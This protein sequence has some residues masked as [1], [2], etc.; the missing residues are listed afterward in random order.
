EGVGEI[1]VVP[2]ADTVRQV[3]EERDHL[4][5]A[6]RALLARMGVPDLAA[7]EARHQQWQ[8]LTQQLGQ[9]ERELQIHLA[10]QSLLDCTARRD[11]LAGRHRGLVEQ[12]AGLQ[13]DASPPTSLQE[14][15]Q[16]HQQ[17]QSDLETAAQA[18]AGADKVLLAA[19]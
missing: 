12:R 7:A 6:R 19:K 9:M 16:S 1:D 3:A 13:E 2:G 10:G 5:D 14:A 18:R 11:E 15:E 8:A 17:A 4:Q